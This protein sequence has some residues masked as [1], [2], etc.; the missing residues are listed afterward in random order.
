MSHGW[1]KLSEKTTACAAL[2]I[3]NINERINSFF[4]IFSFVQELFFF[5]AWLT[6]NKPTNTYI[7][8][9]AFI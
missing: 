5:F 6:Q 7:L 1:S 8:Q 9:Q 4:I 3:A 2:H